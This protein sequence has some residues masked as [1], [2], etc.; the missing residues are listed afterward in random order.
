MKIKNCTLNDLADLQSI[1]R[2]TFAETFGDQNTEEDLKK[3]LDEAYADDVLSKEITDKNSRIFLAYDDNDKILGYLK[4]NRGDAQ[5]EKGYDGSLEIQRIYISKAAKGQGIGSKFMEIAEK[6]AKDWNLSYIWL[7]VWEYNYAAQK[8]YDKKGFKR[9]SE[10][11]F[12]LGD[13]R[14]TDFLLKKE[15]YQS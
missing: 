10:H 2:L 15:I 7:G 14:Q 4:I 9:F 13:D 6:Q 8:F 3:Y 5:T 11:V 1:C 12:T